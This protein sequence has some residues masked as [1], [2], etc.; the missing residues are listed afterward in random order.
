MKHRVGSVGL[1]LFGSGLC[2]LIYQTVWLRQFRL[3]FGASTAASAAVLAIFMGGLGIGGLILG[4]VADRSRNPLALY[5][6]LEI[7]VAVSTALTPVLLIAIRAIYLATGGSVRLGM[8]VATILR[9]ILAALVLAIP[10]TMMGGTLPA[11]ARAVERASD[12]GRRSIGWLYGLNT[13]GAV[14]GALL[15]TFVLIEL[16]G[17]RFTLWLAA[18]VNVLIGLGALILARNTVPGVVTDFSPSDAVPPGGTVATPAPR[19]FVFAAAAIVGFAFLLMELVWYRMLAPL[20]GGTTF[21]FGLILAVALLGIGLGAVAYATKPNRETTMNAFAISCAAEALFIAIPFALGDRLAVFALLI[22]SIG[23]LGFFGFTIGWFMVTAIV[24]LPAAFVSGV[25]FP[26]LIALLGRG[27]E[28]VGRDVGLAYAWNTAGAIVGS[29]AGGFGLLPLLTAPGTWRAVVVLLVAL[30]V[31]SI[32]VTATQA[33]W[34]W[35]GAGAIAMGAAAIAGICAAGPTGFWRHTPIGAGRAD[36]EKATKNKLKNFVSARRRAIVWETDG[37]ESSVALSANDGYAFVVNGKSDGHAILDGGTQVMCGLLGAALHPNPKSALVIGLGTGSTAGWLGSVPSIDRVDV[38]EIEPS[39]KH[40]AEACT[41]VNHQPLDNPK[42]H[43]FFG[44]GREMLLTSKNKYDIIS[45]EPSNPYRAGISSLLTTEFYRAVRSRLTEK[46]IFLQFVQAYEID[47]ATLRMLYASLATT[48]PYVETWET[49][50]GDLLLVSS[51]GPIHYDVTRLR[52]RFAQEPFRTAILNVWRAVNLE[53]VFAHY[54]AGPGTTALMANGSRVNTDDRTQVEYGFAR[55]LGNNAYFQVNDLRNLARSRNDDLPPFEG[56]GLNLMSVEDQRLELVTSEASHA[57][58]LKTL[59][60]DQ[61]VRVRAYIAFLQGDFEVVMR[62]W[63]GQSKRPSDPTELLT[64]AE[65]YA[66]R[67]TDDA[68]GYINELRAYEPI[69]ADAALARLRWKQKNYADATAA[70]VRAFH[71]FRL[72]P[73]PLQI[74]MTRSLEVAMQ[75]ARD[76]P[77]GK[78][79]RALYEAVS[80]PFAVSAMNGARELTLLNIAGALDRDRCGPEAFGVLQIF[81]PDVPWDR[82][83]LRNRLQ[84]YQQTG[85]SRRDQAKKDYEAYLR[86]EP[87]TLSEALGRSAPPPAQSGGAPSQ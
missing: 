33:Q 84:C 48:F 2:A 73:W 37:V 86:N 35:R 41:A 12:V 26:I 80:K 70:L 83:F 68:L 58:D 75:I 56:G 63:I 53:G 40:V 78:A 4:R 25:Q 13:M 82:V 3:I 11:A 79:A 62:S 1:F 64:F 10:T 51:N 16:F 46:G 28:S 72:S 17:N 59:N 36:Q 44:D 85:D 77:T 50:R 27:D 8:T 19:E 76:E 6:V 69:E 52:A 43:V 61:Q 74:T 15:S 45:S 29:I 7:L 65:A 22:R 39:I 60:P 66:D 31:A 47:A 34:R 54:V 23:G 57:P 5:A 18:L 30:S 71:G 24:I 38:Y 14:T 32:I 55:T 42:V 21:T 49:R 67:G 9:L 20:L 81:E 87:L